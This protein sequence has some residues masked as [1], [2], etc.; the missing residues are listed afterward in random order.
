MSRKKVLPQEAEDFLNS[1]VGRSRSTKKLNRRVVAHLFG[2]M[3]KDIRTLE[4]AGLQKFLMHL[5]EEHS[6]KKNTLRTY[7][8]ILRNFLRFHKRGDLSVK[9]KAIKSPKTL[10]IVPTSKEVDQMVEEAG[11]LREKIIIQFLARTGLRVGELC[12]LDL[13]DID[14][15]NLRLIVRKHRLWEPKNAKERVVRMDAATASLIR[16]YISSRQEGRLIDI[17][18]STVRMIVKNVAK[19]AGVR[20]ADKIA[21]HKLRHFFACDFIQ[22]GGD[23]RS[24]QVLLGHSELSTTQIYLNYSFDVVSQ[25]YDKVYGNDK[26]IPG[27]S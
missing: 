1:L 21:P 15:P 17:T 5:E 11:T 18:T 3:Q 14:L 25:A 23:V 4:L 24:L 6:Y 8:I 7:V 26:M 9:I 10:P 2:F 20:N 13:Q 22:R 27:N 19:R 16:E 12:N